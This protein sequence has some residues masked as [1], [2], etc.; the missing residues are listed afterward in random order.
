MGE[1]TLR[2]LVC[3]TAMFLILAVT[4]SY[5]CRQ[6]GTHS[7]TVTLF[8]ATRRDTLTYRF[9][10]EGGG[11]VGEQTL[12]Y[13]V[14]RTA[15]FLILAVTCA[16]ICRQPGTHSDTATLFSATKRDTLRN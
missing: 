14:C 15:M 7:D 3:R 5:I 10:W 12:R 16:Y 4:C 8:S 2:Y 13:L 1:Q 11:A 6:P 9:F